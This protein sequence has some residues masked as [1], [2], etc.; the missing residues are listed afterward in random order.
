MLQSLRVANPPARSYEETCEYV[1]RLLISQIIMVKNPNHVYLNNYQK[2][3]NY[4]LPFKNGALSALNEL[5]DIIPES[6]MEATY[7]DILNSIFIVVGTLPDIL[8]LKISKH[9]EVIARKVYQYML[10]NEQKYLNDFKT[11]KGEQVFSC[12]LENLVGYSI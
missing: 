5:L 11:P 7:H 8:N 6:I 3:Y 2:D 10:K 1:V 12:I 9:P 4:V